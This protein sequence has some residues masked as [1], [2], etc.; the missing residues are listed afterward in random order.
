MEQEVILDD[1]IEIPHNTL[2]VYTFYRNERERKKVERLMNTILNRRP[3][4]VRGF[5]GEGKTR[6]AALAARGI[7]EIILNGDKQF[8]KKYGKLQIVFALP[9]RKLRDEVF[10]NYFPD[11]GFKLKA[12]DEVCPSLKQ[13][14]KQRKDYLIAL[15]EHMKN[16]NCIYQKHIDNLKQAMRNNRIIVTTHTLAILPTVLS[17][18]MKKKPLVIFDE[19]EDFLERISEGLHEDVVEA[20]KQIDEKLYKKIKRML[21]KEQHKYF[22]RHSTLKQLLRDSVFLSAT[23]PRVIEEYYYLLVDRELDTTWVFSIGS[24][25]KDVMIIYRDKLLWKKYSEW[26]ATVLTQVV[27]ISRFAV[28]KYN[29]LGIVSRNYAL[30]NDLQSILEKM[31]YRVVSDLEKDF[32]KKMDVAQ[33][34]IV[35]TKGKLYRGVNILRKGIS[36]I[37]V[38]IGFYQGSFQKEHYPLIADYLTELAGEEVFSTYVREMTY[39][40]NLQSL[41]RFVRK[42]E[43]RHVMIL[44]DWR[45]HEAFYHFFR[46]KLYD[47][48]MRVEVDDLNK[49]AD[50]ARQYI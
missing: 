41:Y 18:L 42:K 8:I 11:C 20:I 35:T 44:F 30:T 12:H 47:E 28:N 22:M 37:N 48:I 14:L 38:V 3:I 23:F 32:R 2:S 27:E 40:K 39:A 50:I 49:V 13:R 25:P 4:L 15:A 6:S 1:P 9:L 45:F 29:V 16:D 5:F 46:N 33:V 43:N 17:Y 24:R 36:D 26:K 31:G 19:A 21:K 10:R 34:I 7:E